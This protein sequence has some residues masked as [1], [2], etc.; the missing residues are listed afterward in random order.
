MSRGRFRGAGTNPFQRRAAQQSRLQ[1]RAQAH[2]CFIR[3]TTLGMQVLV[4]SHKIVAV[5]NEA[6]ALLPIAR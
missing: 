1:A 4:E 6:I 5:L 2:A 3:R